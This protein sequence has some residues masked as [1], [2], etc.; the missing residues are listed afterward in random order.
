[1]TTPYRETREQKAYRQ[2]L[3][4]NR[5]LLSN[6]GY[7]VLQQAR[8]VAYAAFTT[9]PAYHFQPQEYYEATQK[10]R[11]VTDELTDRDRVRLE[12]RTRRVGRSRLH[13]SR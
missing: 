4:G 3:E 9:R 5:E 12:D 7:S 2:L 8:L 10:M 13:R 6:A 1:M 11:R